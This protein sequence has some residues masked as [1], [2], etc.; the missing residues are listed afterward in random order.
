MYQNN[1]NR[2]VKMSMW[3]LY[4]LNVDFRYGFVCS[5]LS[6]PSAHMDAKWD[7]PGF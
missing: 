3:A 7:L 4:G 5:F 6:I 2:P 1:V